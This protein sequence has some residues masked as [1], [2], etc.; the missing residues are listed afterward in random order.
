MLQL[1]LSLDPPDLVAAS[2]LSA[3]TFL[4]SRVLRASLSTRDPRELA[5]TW[6]SDSERDQ[7]RFPWLTTA[8]SDY[9]GLA[10]RAAES[11]VRW[12]ER[13]LAPVLG[14]ADQWR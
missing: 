8:N 3:S 14:H 9:A 13:L 5:R 6:F 12:L 10:M 2:V 7:R 11:R 4:R 1:P